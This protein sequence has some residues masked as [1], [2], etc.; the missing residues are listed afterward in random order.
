MDAGQTPIEEK[1]GVESDSGAHKDR[2]C[3]SKKAEEAAGVCGPRLVPFF[4][5]ERHR[6]RQ[7]I[8][9]NLHEIR[10]LPAPCKR[11]EKQSGQG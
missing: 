7:D 11:I 9:M 8:L 10:G 4:I 2:M 5:P 1:A 6:G 3:T